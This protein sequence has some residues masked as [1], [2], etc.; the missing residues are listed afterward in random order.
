VSIPPRAIPRLGV[1]GLLAN[2]VL[3][4]LPYLSVY[5]TLVPHAVLSNSNRVKFPRGI[6]YPWNREEEIYQR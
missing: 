5:H 6:S 3:L 4:E 1:G 2:P